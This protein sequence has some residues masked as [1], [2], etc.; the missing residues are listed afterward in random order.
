MKT[1]IISD[2]HLGMTGEDGSGYYSLLSSGL[3]VSQDIKDLVN[4]KTNSFVKTIT[5]FAAGEDITLVGCGDVLDLAMSQINP[6]MCDLARLLE[7]LPMISNFY[8]I[9]GNHDHHVWTLRSELYSIVRHLSAGRMPKEG[10]IFEPTAPS[11]EPFLLFTKMLSTYLKRPLTV[12][13]AYPTL[14]MSFPCGQILITHGHLFGDIYTKV[15]NVLRPYITGTTTL[16]ADTVVNAPIIEFIYWLIGETGDKMGASGGLSS[17]IYSDIQKG[18]SSLVNSLIER[19]VDVLLSD[20]II[21]GI[22]NS[23]ERWLTKKILKNLVAKSIPHVDNISSSDRHKDTSSAKES[24]NNWLTNVVKDDNFNVFVSGHTHVSY[25]FETNINGKK[26]RCLNPGGWEIE[27][28][29]KGSFEADSNIILID[30]KEIR[31]VKI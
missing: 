26:I 22:P 5:D 20:G 30:D 8:Y 17:I 2:T 4:F 21:K 7:K 11:G 13:I 28:V 16:H 1:V 18:K 23:W 27:P 3:N 14:Q 10:S 6:A 9:V 24:V 15:S 29:V 19:A 31:L 25:D 12:S